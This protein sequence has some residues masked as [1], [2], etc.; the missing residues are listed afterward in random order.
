MTSMILDNFMHFTFLF[1]VIPFYENIR[2]HRHLKFYLI[3]R[4]FGFIKD[5]VI[6][7]KKDEEA[8]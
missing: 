5:Y 7:V 2:R 3:N 1:Y 8:I 6:F 4:P